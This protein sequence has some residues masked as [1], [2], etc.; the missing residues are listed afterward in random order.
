MWVKSE[1]GDMSNERRGV[2]YR[3]L[4]SVK[5]LKRG[6]TRIFYCPEHS[7]SVRVL[8]NAVD[9]GLDYPYATPRPFCQILV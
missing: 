3:F 4:G 1:R 2:Q 6:E 8:A 5:K 9:N 7:A